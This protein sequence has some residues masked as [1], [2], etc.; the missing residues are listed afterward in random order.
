MPNPWDND[1]VVGQVA[2]PVYGTPKAVDPYKAEDQQIQ[3]EGNARS[4]AAADR[5][6]AAAE[7]SAA[8]DERSAGDASYNNTL[9]LRTDYDSLPIVKEY[10]VGIAQLGAALKRSNDATGDNA[11]IY[12][13]AKAMDPGSVVRESEMGMAASGDSV[14]A[15]TLAS[16]QKQLELGGGQLSPTVRERLKR[17]IATKIASMNQAYSEQRIRF[18]K[19]ATAFGIDP[20]RVT[21]N[22]DGD[23]YMDDIKAYHAAQRGDDRVE[24]SAAAP[25]AVDLPDVGWDKTPPSDGMW[26]Q[27]GEA[28]GNVVSGVAQ[29]LTALPDMAANAIG[30]TLALPADALGFEGVARDL[31]N[32]IT[33]G[34]LVEK[35]NP[36][37]EDGVGA[38]VRMA[39]QFGG[40]VAGFPQRAAQAVTNR[41]VGKVPEQINALSV[42]PTLAAGQRQGVELLPA[43]VGGEA[44]KGL[45][46]A[47][48][49]APFSRGGITAVSRRAADQMDRAARRASDNVGRVVPDDEAGEA[50]RRGGRQVIQKQTDRASRYYESAAK[51]AEGVRVATPNA[52][53]VIDEQIALKSQAGEMSADIVGE[54]QKV[55]RSLEQAGGISVSGIRE[56]RTLLGAMAR[57][58]KLRGTDA[59]RIFK[60][61]LDAASEDMATGLREA[62]KQGA[63][64]LFRRADTLWKE[65]IMDIDEVWEPIIGKG[66]SGEDIV[67]A[68][69]GMARGSRGGVVRAQ[70]ILNEMPAEEKGDF[71]ATAIDRM[72]R[73]SASVQDETGDLFSSETF[74]TNWSKMSGKGKSALFGNGETRRSLDDIATL[75]SARRDTAQLASKSNTPMGITANAA[76]YGALAVS[77][78]AAAVAGVVLQYSTGRLLASPAFTK[79]VARMPKGEGAIR[80]HMKRLTTIASQN[81]SLSDEIS[82]VS[83]ALNDNMPRAGTLAAES[84][85]PRE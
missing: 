3:R 68:I 85:E 66:K 10:R 53:R 64:R 72:G 60:S 8:A 27:L 29:G 35:A 52:T 43:D 63:A 61:V 33:I 7:R 37:P 23:I 49:Q 4:A 12:D 34:G 40:G 77:N 62:G 65:R 74:L 78:P 71:I 36:T 20:A 73:A 1:P 84:P 45:T 26:G 31:R 44:V 51:Q 21:G 54:L 79:W 75:A 15:R 38:G 82:V 2:A 57:N 47:A 46:S 17:E 56:A 13:Y 81:P 11:L 32:P 69:E 25:G 59:G 22:H 48:A 50:I 6:A 80:A 14:F 55:K 9:K 19:D 58:D 16:A 18:A 5:Q 28:T 83:R 76:P 42:N 41:I 70:R 30:A 67:K 39:A 24:T